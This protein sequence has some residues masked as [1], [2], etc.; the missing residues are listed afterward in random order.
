MYTLGSTIHHETITADMMRVVVVDI[1]NATARVPVPTEDVQTVGQ[2]LGNFILWP[3]RLSRAIVK[4]VEAQGQED[5]NESLQQQLQSPQHIILEQLGVLAVK[6]SLSPI[7]LEMPPEVT[8][9]K[10]S[11]SFF[12][13]QRDIFE[14]LSGTDMLCISVLQLWLLYLHRLTIEKKNDHIY[15]FIDPVAIQGVGNKGEEVQNYLLEAFVN[16][17]KQVYLAPYLQQ[18]HW[19]LLLI[20][21]QQFLVVLLCSL[22]K[23][24]HTLAIKNTLILLQGTHILSRKKLQFIAPT[25]SRQ[26]GSFECGYYVMRHMQKIISANVVDSWKLIFDDTSPMEQHVIKDVRE[27]WA[28]FLLTICK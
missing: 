2:A 11:L 3:L 17:K 24:P 13:C 26:P 9:R 1:R 23:K 28:A 8:N 18:G 10:S 5:M 16:G 4:K 12:I 22:H 25:C 6:I 20:L 21:P 14:I 15:G 27:Q 19:Q 7:E